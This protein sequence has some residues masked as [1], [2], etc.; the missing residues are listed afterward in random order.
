MSKTKKNIN[1]K[2]VGERI[3]LL[4]GSE[5]RQ[6]FA[7]RHGIKLSRLGHIENGIRKPPLNFLLRLH[8][9]K[10]ISLEFILNGDNS[11][12]KSTDRMKEHISLQEVKIY[13]RDLIEKIENSFK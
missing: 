3:R 13:L 5:S 1:Y 10:E 6:K 9:D 4:R 12:F 7:D 8:A 2:E 11:D